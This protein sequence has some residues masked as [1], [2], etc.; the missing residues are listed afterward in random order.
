[1]GKAVWRDKIT[2]SEEVCIGIREKDIHID[3]S[4]DGDDIA[5]PSSASAL[6][7]GTL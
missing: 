7:A 1:M 6:A 4:P 2:E 3:A 5:I